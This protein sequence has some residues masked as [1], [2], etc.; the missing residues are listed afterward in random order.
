MAAPGINDR[1]PDSGRTGVAEWFEN[2]AF[3]RELYPYMFTDERIEAADEHVDKVL[4][5]VGIEVRTVLDLCCG[6]GRHSIAL[7][8]KGHRVTGVDRT[9]FLLDKAKQRAGAEDVDV[10][11]VLED[12]RR[13]VRPGAY[14]LVL[15]LFTS[16][17][18]FD[19]MQDDVKVLANIHQSLKPGGACVIDTVG[20]ELLAERR[21]P[22]TSREEHDGALFVVR[23]E[24]FDGWSRIRNEWLLIKDGKVST[25]T[26]HHTLYSGQELKDRLVQVGFA[27][28][29]L[30]G[31]LVGEEYGP[32]GSRLIAV[33]WKAGG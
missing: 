17:G 33:G 26:F 7:A 23:H 3:W 4:A 20:K 13:F 24:I 15:N 6:P 2:E 16:F 32:G 5:L 1:R 11:W 28:A 25:Y 14:D 8:K 22:T 21:Q 30:Y 27:R 10:E 29:K 31:S 19:D 18:Y 12:M 9:P